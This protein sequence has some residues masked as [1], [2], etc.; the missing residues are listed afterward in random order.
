MIIFYDGQCDFC[1]RRM[2]ALKAK[3]AVGVLVFED[4]NDP[5]LILELF[6]LDYQTCIEEIHAIEGNVLNAKVYKGL[7]VYLRAHEK[8]GYKLARFALLP[9][10]YH[11]LKL[12]Y[13]LVARFR[14]YL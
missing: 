8:M 6:G 13:A 12:C 10:V 4:I 14:S 1:R 7:D 2:R 11:V 3:D 5:S 9:V